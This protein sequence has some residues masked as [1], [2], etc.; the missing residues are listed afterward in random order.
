MG[1]LGLWLLVVL[2][3]LVLGGSLGESW[4]WPLAWVALVPLWWVT[5]Q[6]QAGW[7]GALWGACYHGAALSWLLHL[8][9][10]TWLGIPWG[11]SLAVALAIWLFVTLWGALGVGIWAALTSQVKPAWRRLP[12]GIALWCAGETLAHHTS[13]WW[14]TLALTQ[15]PGNPTLLHLGQLAG[16]VTPVAWLLLVNGVL[17]LARSYP[18][19]LVLPLALGLWV[20]GQSL[21]WFL[22]IT[23]PGESIL[24][25][26]S[27]GV[28]QPNVPNPVRFTPQGRAQMSARL[29]AGY[30]ALV[31][32]GADIV[33]TPEGALGQEWTPDHPLATF[34]QRWRTPVVLGAYGRRTGRLTN[35]LFVLDGQ[36]QVVSRY[37]KVSLVPLGEFIPLERWLGPWVRRISALPES[38]TPGSLTQSVQTPWGPVIAGICYDSAFAAV[39]REQARR[40]GEW[41]ITAANNDPYPPRMMRQHQAQD[42]LRAIETDRWLVRAT[43]TGISGLISPRGRI[44]WQAPPQQDHIQL[45]RLYRRRSQTLYGRYGDWLTPVLLGIGG[46]WWLSRL[47]LPQDRKG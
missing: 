6:R 26:L 5:E 36:G 42:V 35:S 37:D 41:I 46:G 7:G 14:S 28:I 47:R 30:I 4:A 18:G 17:A 25:S 12:V 3:G 11:L 1:Q 29:Q 31:Q 34:I 19:R 10:L 24:A 8:H 32:Q 38:Q 9:P 27:V 13:L 22:Q 45:V 43:N 2:S 16:P 20:L 15:S 39:F 33:I 40:G 21:G 44:L 23:A